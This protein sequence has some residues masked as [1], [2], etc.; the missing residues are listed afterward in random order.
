MECLILAPIFW[1][2]L[3]SYYRRYIVLDS[4]KTDFFIEL[5][6]LVAFYNKPHA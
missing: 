3:L 5:P 4:F 6:Y 2:F 1:K